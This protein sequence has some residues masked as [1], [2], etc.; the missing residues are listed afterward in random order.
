[1]AAFAEIGWLDW[2]LL[3]VVLLS[4]AVGLWRGFAFEALALGGWVVAWFAAHGF[5]PH[6]A[7]HV[8]VGV[9][10]GA[11]RH[12]ASFAG[13][14]VVAL[15]ACALLAHLVRALVRATPLSALDRVLGAG[16]GLLRGAVL[17]LV[18]ATVVLMTPARES[19][20]WRG[21]RGALVL[22][23]TILTL[24]PLMPSEARRWLP[25]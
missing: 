8:P 5:A 4:G 17:L 18:L 15:L 6:A 11:L 7:P 10:G 13:C 25:D 22:D 12:A 20:S 3:G 21:S 9:P 19:A 2:A 16:F 1:M 23:S 14:F 24:K